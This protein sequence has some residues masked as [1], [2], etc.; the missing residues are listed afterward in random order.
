MKKIIATINKN[1]PIK[2]DCIESITFNTDV[3]S[4]VENVMVILGYGCSDY[5]LSFKEDKQ[6][7]EKT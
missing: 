2:D 1:V 5:N 7:S 3:Q 4:D 6:C